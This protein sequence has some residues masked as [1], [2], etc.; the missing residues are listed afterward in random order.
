M[1]DCALIWSL[2]PPVFFT[3]ARQLLATYLLPGFA[4]L[5]VL[6]GVALA[7]QRD[8]GPRSPFS[9]LLRWQVTVSALAAGGL[10]VYAGR[11]GE[12]ALATVAAALGALLLLSALVRSLRGVPGLVGVQAVGVAAL[13][14]L[15]VAVARP[16]LDDRLSAKTIL[17]RAAHD[18][19]LEGRPLVFPLSEEHSA[20]F[21]AHLYLGRE[22]E[23]HP[24][25]G[26]ALLTEK[27][28]PGSNDVLFVKRD[29]WQRLDADLRARAEIVAQT[30]NWVAFAP[31][32]HP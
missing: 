3:F 23:H 32:T 20:D 19:R 25:T 14:F 26:K 17:Q 9:L 1:L 8:G 15:A 22:T 11:R 10:A 12:P 31:R 28:R 27:L 7:G 5:A 18:T 24:D 21:Y 29:A 16:A 4:G 13:I 2:V 6:A 30:P